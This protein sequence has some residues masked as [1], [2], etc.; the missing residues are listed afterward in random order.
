MRTL[1]FFLVGITALSAKVEFQRIPGVKPRNI[2]VI[3]V[4]DQR[5]D[6]MGFI[7]HPF[8]EPPTWTALLVTVLIF[9]MPL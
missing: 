3:L 5:Y 8:L 2:V 7:G 6:A 9:P 1:L 4:D